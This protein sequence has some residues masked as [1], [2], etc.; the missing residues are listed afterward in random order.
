MK[1]LQLTLAISLLAAS[2]NSLADSPLGIQVFGESG[3]ETT[4]IGGANLMFTGMDRHDNSLTYF[5]LGFKTVE[6][7]SPD[8]D[9]S[10]GQIIIGAA[11]PWRL[12]P[13]LEVG[14]DPV[15]MLGEALS[16]REEYSFS[17][18]LGMGA[19][20]S[21]N[22]RLSLDLGYKLHHFTTDEYYE[23]HGDHR[24]YEYDGISFG[25]ASIGLN[26]SF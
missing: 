25:T 7:Y 5:G 12:S 2:T 18:Y 1:L 24:H 10:Y 11:L 22:R 8:I 13:Y 3:N 15:N 17:G 4:S 23:Y 20:F 16:D 9:G 14:I 21:L 19:R 26:L 6:G